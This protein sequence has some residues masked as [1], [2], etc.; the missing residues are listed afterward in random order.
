MKYRKEARDVTQVFICI[1]IFHLILQ[2]RDGVVMKEL[3]SWRKI[4]F[5]R[6]GREKY[7]TKG[8]VK[9]LLNLFHVQKGVDDI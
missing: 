1:E 6:P 4:K 9:S 2:N 3:R 5:P 7:L 8:C